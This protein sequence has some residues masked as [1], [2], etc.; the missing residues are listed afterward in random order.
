[1]DPRFEQTLDAAGAGLR[2]HWVAL[3]GVAVAA[4]L[5]GGA[6]RVLSPRDLYHAPPATQLI[7]APAAVLADQTLPSWPG[8]RIPEYV[9]GTDLTRA[10]AEVTPYPAVEDAYAE[11]EVAAR[12]RQ[13]AT[14]DPPANV[15]QRA[16]YA[17]EAAVQ[18]VF[19]AEQAL[20]SADAVEAYPAMA[21][22]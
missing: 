6:A 4:V 2:R 8:G 10:M 20:D 12:I 11:L 1:M 13:D 14:R 3:V 17:D 19:S 16:A 22:G 7:S 5:G 18:T 9:V 21:P 15:Y